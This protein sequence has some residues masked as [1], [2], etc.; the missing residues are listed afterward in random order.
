MSLILQRGIFDHKAYKGIYQAYA[1][2]RSAWHPAQPIERLLEQLRLHGP[3]LISGF[4]SKR[5]YSA[6]AE[7]KICAGT[8]GSE[9]FLGRNIYGWLPKHRIT[10]KTLGTVHAMIIVGAQTT[11]TSQHVF[12]INPSNKSIPG[13]PLSQKI[14]AISYK[15]LQTYIVS[16]STGLF[17]DPSPSGAISY[18]FAENLT[19]PN[20]YAIH[21]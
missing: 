16:I 19:G 17:S 2:K 13:N 5:C 9:P 15:T 18:P 11:E 12:L 10:S 7:I 21:C 3:H 20:D 4:F 14:Y 1:C 8:K 6:P